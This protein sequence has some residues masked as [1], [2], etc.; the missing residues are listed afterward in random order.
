MLVAAS[1]HQCNELEHSHQ[2]YIWTW[3]SS[4]GTL[5]SCSVCCL[6]QTGWETHEKRVGTA[7]KYVNLSAVT[8][9]AFCLGSRQT[10]LHYAGQHSSAAL[11]LRPVF[12]DTVSPLQLFVACVVLRIGFCSQD[13]DFI[14]DAPCRCLSPSR[15]YSC[16]VCGS[17]AVNSHSL[18]LWVHL[19][20]SAHSPCIHV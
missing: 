6:W 5:P 3:L 7:C 9:V 1:E 14:V 18:W 17:T 12:G 2:G 13:T 16:F 19:V 4:T 10:R 20:T 8:T 11:G 15:I